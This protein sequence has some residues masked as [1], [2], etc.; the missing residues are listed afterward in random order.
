MLDDY[1]LRA[2]VVDDLASM[3]SMMKTQL[4]SIGVSRVS[5]APNAAIAINKMR[6]EKFDLVLLDYYLGDATDGQQL[7]ELI[8]NESLIASS[9]LAVMVTG[10]TN[11]GSVAQVAE[12]TPDAYLL[13]PFTAEKL[14][15][16]LLPVIERKLGVRHAT[17]KTPG[18]KP[19][20]DQYDAGHYEAVIALVDAF[21]EREGPHADTARLKGDALIQMGDYVKAL[22]HYKRLQDHFSWAALGVARVQA[23]LHHTDAAIATL[24]KLVADAPHYMHAIDMLADTYIAADQPEKAMTILEQACA[25]SPTVNRMRAT[26]RVA[27]QIDDDNRTVL[28]AGKVVEAN[29]FAVAQDFT[30]HARLVRGLV[31][32]GQMDKAVA[33]V[34]R[35]ESEVPQAKQSASIQASKGYDLAK[36]IEK[37]KIELASMPEGIRSRRLP[38]LT[39]KE[40]RLENI[41]NSLA[42]LE[43]SAKEGIFISE[44]FIASGHSEKAMEAA[45]TAMAH[46]EMMPAL[47]DAAWQEAVKAQ[48]VAKTKTRILD[49]LNLLRANKTK[50]ALILFM[51]LV[52]HTPPDLTPQLLANV[53]TTVI[54]LKHKGQNVTEFMP[55]A[56]VALERLKEKYPNYER[57]PGLIEAFGDS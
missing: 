57:L 25:I 26:S 46:G 32:T 24:E 34:V 29:K 7:L 39:E 51:Q 16:H 37:E 17:K 45:S 48:A 10:E 55:A 50:E 19:I 28:W 35:F 5:E 2:L 9:A 13:K 11:Y 14:Y 23:H 8:R 20:Y 1:N 54:A 41:A 30:D 47:G 53:V 38:L 40:A 42:S 18:L 56:R 33:T 22:K 3:R 31:K 49:G 36:Q 12:H 4:G 15:D 27:E 6:A 21:S 43:H 52:E 44:V